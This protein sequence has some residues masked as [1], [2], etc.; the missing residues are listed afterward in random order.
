MS[1]GVFRATGLAAAE[2]LPGVESELTRIY[3]GI[4][5]PRGSPPRA[6]SP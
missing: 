6:P 2:T 1:A 4:A 5:G 3:A